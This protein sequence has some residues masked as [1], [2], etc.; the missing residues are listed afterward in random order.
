MSLRDSILQA[1]DLPVFPVEVPE[2]GITVFL[3]TL[4]GAERLQLEK[5]LSKDQKTDGPA[6]CRIV[7]ATLCD[8]AGKLLFNYP[9]DIEVLNTKSV[10][11]LHRLFDE[12]MKINALSK[13]DVDELAKN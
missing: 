7:C 11:A 9:Q 13:Q 4:T 10:K 5:D 1:K 2:W 3:K 8:E 12:A 6:M